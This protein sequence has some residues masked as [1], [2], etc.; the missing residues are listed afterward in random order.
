MI[1]ILKYGEVSTSDIFARAVPEAD[2]AGVVSE[3]IANVRANGDKNAE[4]TISETSYVFKNPAEAGDTI[5]IKAIDA[6][7]VYPDSN[8][9]SG[10]F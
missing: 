7:G 2:V 4:K 3:I 9:A 5:Y 6:D 10:T 1:K 8:F